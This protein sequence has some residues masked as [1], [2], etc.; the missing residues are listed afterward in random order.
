MQDITE[1]VR[2]GYNQAVNNYQK[3]MDN[4]RLKLYIYKEFKALVNKGKILE[5]GC[6]N[7]FPIGFDLLEN[8][9]DYTGIDISEKQIEL[10]KKDHPKHFE[11]ASMNDYLD[12]VDC[13]SLDGIVT[14]FA[15]FHLPKEGRRKLYE[16]IFDKLRINSHLL[17]TCHPGNWEGYIENWLGAEK[18]FWSTLPN[19]WYQKNIEEIG[20][21]MVTVHRTIAKFNGKD[22]V[23][24]FMLYRKPSSKGIRS[25]F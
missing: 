15:D 13:N 23:Q 17:F 14:M 25:N 11:V 3:E 7:G 18:M 24:Y 16:K 20:F 1:L 12:R 4:S 22:E 10:A 19:E 6:G 8:D 5:L 9:F 21:V 2:K